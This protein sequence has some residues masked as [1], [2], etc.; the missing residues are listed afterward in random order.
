LEVLG[1]LFFQLGRIFQEP[2]RSRGPLVLCVYVYV[3][4][5]GVV[6]N[7]AGEDVRGKPSMGLR[8]RGDEAQIA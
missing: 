5:G 4:V 6:V 7:E 1:F 8:N 2:V 3:C